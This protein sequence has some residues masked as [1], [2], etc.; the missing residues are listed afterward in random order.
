MAGCSRGVCPLMRTRRRRRC[1][2]TQ[3]AQSV[4]CGRAQV[5][6]ICSGGVCRRKKV[7]RCKKTKGFR[8]GCPGQ[9]A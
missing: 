5:V 7:R 2:K 3:R 1:R 6:S 4:T 8:G 9:C